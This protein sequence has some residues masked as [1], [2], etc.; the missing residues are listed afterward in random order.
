MKTFI[1][2]LHEAGKLL[3]QTLL[4]LWEVLTDS[5]TILWDALNTPKAHTAT[6]GKETDIASRF[7]KGFLISKHRRLTLRKSF[8]NLMLCAPTGAGKTTRFIIKQLLLLKNCSII[9]NDPSGE[10]YAKTSGYLSQFFKL[11]IINFSDSKVSFGYNLLSRIKSKQDINKIAD[12]LVRASLESGKGNDPF[13]G[14]QTRALLSICIRIVLYQSEP[15]RNMANVLHMVKLFS[16]EPKTT[17]YIVVQSKDEQLLLDYKAMVAMPEKTRQNIVASATASLQIFESEEIARMTA[18]DHI[19]LEELRKTPTIVFLHNKIGDMKFITTLQSI[20]FTQLYTYLLDHLPKKDELPIHI[21]MEEASSLYIEG[22]PIFISNTR[23]HQVSNF[24]CVQSLQQL[25][26]QYGDDALS[27]FANCGTRLFLPGTS[28]LQTLKEIEVLSGK[29]TVKNKEGKEVVKSLVT[30]DEARRL[31]ENR[32]LI[33]SGNVPI[34]K[35]YS[36]PY[37]KSYKYK[38][39][40]ALPPKPFVQYIPDMPVPLLTIR[41]ATSKAKPNHTPS[42]TKRDEKGEK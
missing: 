27:I 6:F 24:L 11:K 30:I 4:F 10:V 19:Q 38:K 17:D 20:F 42:K 25:K 8:E 16:A 7:N 28:D 40:T 3:A 26:S 12:L 18:I 21:I 5:L 39:L 37:Y 34:I 15:Y 36:S 14:L 31:K 35:G 23:K 9:V 13:W 2:I 41:K 32:T 29:T 33:L 22:L 1:L